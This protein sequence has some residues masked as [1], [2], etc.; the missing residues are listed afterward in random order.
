[1]RGN[2]IN[3]KSFFT[4]IAILALVVLGTVGCTSTQKEGVDSANNVAGNSGDE[5]T[6]SSEKYVT[7]KD[8]QANPSKYGD[9][10]KVYF[11]YSSSCSI[12]KGIE[13]EIQQ[14]DSLIPSDAVFIKVDFDK[15]TKL[16]QKYGVMTQYTFVQIDTIGQEVARWSAS[17]LSSAVAGI[18]S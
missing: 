9:S 15:E 17:N 14:D 16:R 18:R 12:C 2:I 10:T 8:Y 1:V 3:K 13:R 5:A 6:S 4:I 7:L 11:F